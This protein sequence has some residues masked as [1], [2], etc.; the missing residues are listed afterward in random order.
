MK[1]IF[2][3]ISFFL[4]MASCQKELSLAD[5]SVN[6]APERVV[7][8]IVITDSTQSDYDSLVY[9]Y[10]PDKTRE[11]H[12]N[13]SGDSTT[14][15]YYYDTDNRFSKLEDEKAIY[16]T[17]NDVAKRISFQYNSSGQ[18]V[19]TLTD[20]AT[21]TGIKAYY[22]NNLSATGKS[23]IV[24][25]TF[26]NSPSYN[27]DWANRII[28]N[29]LS[30]DD[31]LLYDSC[32][33]I[34]KVSGVLTTRVSAYNYDTE[35]NATSISKLTYHDE[36]LS[37][38]GTVTVTRDKPAPDYEALREK[39]FHNLAN[40]Y[41]TGSV[42][43]DDNYPLFSFPGRMY[44]SIVYTGYSINGGAIPLQVY[45]RSEFNNTYNDDLLMKSVITT[46]LQGQGNTH[47]VTV[48]RYYY[49]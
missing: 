37:E 14:R 42:L 5:P 31:Y 22:N 32:I 3:V 25:D 19:E 18:L 40:W 12:Y 10:L 36:Q 13:H 33:F 30:S 27:L 45:N 48:I 7:S 24:Y 41:Q 43:Q 17:N 4:L 6:P 38:W 46:S 44:K 49:R 23:I 26:Y 34:N 9:R 28:Y 20:F 47:Y 16:Y 1:K 21:V 11:V 2:P 8:A 39:L 29:T 35:K 15:T